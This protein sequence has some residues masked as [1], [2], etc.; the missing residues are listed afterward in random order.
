PDICRQFRAGRMDVL[1]WT[2]IA[3]LGERAA[4]QPD[5]HDLWRRR[6][7]DLR[8]ARSAQ[9]GADPFWKRL[10]PGGNRRRGGGHPDGEPDPGP[11]PSTARHQRRPAT[12]PGK[13]HD[14]GGVDEH[15]GPHRDLWEWSEQYDACSIIHYDDG[16]QPAP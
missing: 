4:V 8:V 14:A 12:P 15:P 2:I 6:P 1:R 13:Q 5:R 10:R 11:Q 16:R 7:V 9:P 3:H